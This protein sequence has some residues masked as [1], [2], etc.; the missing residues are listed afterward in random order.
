MLGE[1]RILSHNLQ[2]TL[3]YWG[4]SVT[5]QISTQGRNLEAGTEEI[6]LPGL[7]PTAFPA[8]FHTQPRTTYRGMHVLP[9][10]MGCFLTHQSL[11]KKIHYWFAC[12]T[13]NRIFFYWDSSPQI[14][15]AH[16]RSKSKKQNQPNK[17]VEKYNHFFGSSF[18]FE[19]SQAAQTFHEAMYVCFSP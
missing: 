6:L 4:K 18:L 16:V 1:K 10:A 11:I 12:G 14:T 13:S 7:C 2:F 17:P 5:W 8:G 9:S 15:P 19:N 3:H